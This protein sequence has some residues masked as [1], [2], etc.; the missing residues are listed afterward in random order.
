MTTFVCDAGILR[1]TSWTMSPS[2]VRVQETSSTLDLYQDAEWRARAGSPN[3]SLSSPR[4]PVLQTEL[5]DS[6]P[7][8]FQSPCLCPHQPTKPSRRTRG[9]FIRSRISTQ[10]NVHGGTWSVSPTVL[11]LELASAFL[12]AN[13][14]LRARLP[15]CEETP[16]AFGKPSIFSTNPYLS[17]VGIQCRSTNT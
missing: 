3:G 2:I 17:Y 14:L 1:A 5:Q 11:R 6:G 4:I 9:S 16:L 12:Y 13:G 10:E 8:H 15:S 7:R